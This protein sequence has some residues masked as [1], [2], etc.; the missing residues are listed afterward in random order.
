MK[1]DYQFKQSPNQSDLKEIENWLIDEKNKSNEGFYSNWTIIE[2]AFNNKKLITVK[3]NNLPIGFLVW[4]KGEIYAE[5]DILEIK[6]N[7]RNKGIGEKFFNQISNHFTSEGFLAL[8]LFCSPRESEKFWKKMN[9]VKFPIRRYSESD[10]TYY[11]PLIDVLRCTETNDYLN[12]IELWNVEPNRI[13]NNEPEWTWKVE[14][15]T[16]KLMLP[17]IQ[18]CDCNWN[19]RWT[20][21][22]KMIREDKVKYFALKN[23]RIDYSPFLY[24]NELSE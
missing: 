23:N 22:G 16:N 19:L 17:I 2:N 10:L 13:K 20:K 9:F 7:L 4:S 24:I 15:E 18:P 5:I 3:H 1:L 6:P 14:S 8:K 11:K 21:N 12:K